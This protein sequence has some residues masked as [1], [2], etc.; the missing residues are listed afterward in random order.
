MDPQYVPGSPDRDGM[1]GTPEI[2]SI[3]MIKQI[4]FV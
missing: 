3:L 1:H 4:K 2:L